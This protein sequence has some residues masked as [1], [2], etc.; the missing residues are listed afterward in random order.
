MSVSY[1]PTKI[2]VPDGFG[3]LMEDLTKQILAEQP[4]DL[5]GFAATYLRGKLHYMKGRYFVN[6]L[7]FSCLKHTSIAI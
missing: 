7:V 2:K 3:T 4:E 1:A 5:I 6:L